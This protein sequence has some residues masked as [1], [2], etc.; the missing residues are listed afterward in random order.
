[1]R[2]LPPV[3]P[4]K[5]AAGRPAVPAARTPAAAEPVMYGPVK[6]GEILSEIARRYKPQGVSTPQMTVAIYQANHQAFIDGNMNRLRRGVSLFLPSDQAARAV[7]QHEAA[8]VIRAQSAPVR[9]PAAGT[10]S[11]S[12]TLQILAP[13]T[14]TA[15][16]PG[17]EAGDLQRRLDQLRR[18][19]SE[20]RAENQQLRAQL[21][22]LEQQTRLL[23]AKVLALPA[24]VRSAAP[25][26]V[27]ASS[28][29]SVRPSPKPAGTVTPPAAKSWWRE[30]LW[31]AVIIAVLLCIGILLSWSLFLRHRPSRYLD[32]PQVTKGD[33]SV[34]LVWRGRF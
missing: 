8:T 24:P 3:L 25:A 21:A 19:N 32:L 11:A 5:A 15:L 33:Q 14:P 1:M 13:V 34:Q 22:R 4:A 23:A 20:V 29:Q 26:A 27:P 6:R 31:W 2:P 16:P 12:S 17:T 18:T 7:T 28:R 30:P 9:S 10:G